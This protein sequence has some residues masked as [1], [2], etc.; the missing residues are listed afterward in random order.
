MKD[1]VV[2]MAVILPKSNFGFL[3]LCCSLVFTILSRF[4][5]TVTQT[6]TKHSNEYTETELHKTISVLQ[7]RLDSRLFTL[8]GGRQSHRDVLAELF[9]QIG[10]AHQFLSKRYASSKNL[11]FNETRILSNYHTA[12]AKSHY[13]IC[14]RFNKD[15][16]DAHVNLAMLSPPSIALQYLHRALVLS[17]SHLQCRINLGL[18]YHTVLQDYR[19]AI[20][21]FK[22]SIGYHPNSIDLHYNLA[23]SYA[24]VGQHNA[25]IY[26]YQRILSSIDENDLHSSIN[27][28]AVY[29]QQGDFFTALNFYRNAL[30]AFTFQLSRRV[31]LADDAVLD[32]FVNC[33]IFVL[34]DWHTLPNPFHYDLGIMC[35]ATNMTKMCNFCKEKIHS[36]L[37]DPY[38]KL[39]QLQNEVDLHYDLHLLFK[40][41]GNALTQIGDFSRAMGYYYATLSL[42]HHEVSIF[43]NDSCRNF[44]MNNVSKEKFH[45]INLTEDSRRRIRKACG[46]MYNL[47]IQAACHIFHSGRG[48]SFFSVWKWF[49][50]LIWFIDEYQLND[51]GDPSFLPFDTLGLPVDLEWRKRI[52]EK[53]AARFS[54]GATTN[55]SLH[56]VSSI[57]QRHTPAQPL[58]ISFLSQDFTD[59]P[60]AHLV[61]GLFVN[62]R[63]FQSD[64][65]PVQYLVYSY[66]KND[67][68]TCRHNIEQL[69]GGPST[70]R[71][72]FFDL[73]EADD[74]TAIQSV[75]GIPHDDTSGC[76][77]KT[78]NVSNCCYGGKQ[79]DIVFDL[80]G[81]TFKGRP[82]LVAARLAP[83]Q[84][85]YLV[86]PGTS[87]SATTDYIVGDK[88]VTPPE[89]APF[90]TEKLALMPHSYQANYYKRYVNEESF[91]ERGSEEW[92]SI[93]KREGLPTSR[94]V[95]VF[96][97]FNKQDKLEPMI[98][99]SWMD[100]LSQVS[101]SVLWLL[102]PTHTFQ[103][104]DG[105]K[106]VERNV[107]RQATVSGIL[108][109]DRIIFARRVTKAMH[110]YR[111]WAAD[112]FLDTHLYGAHTSA[113]DALITG[114]PVLTLVGETFSSRVGLSLLE[115][116]DAEFSSLLTSWSF[117]E[118]V[119]TAADFAK[120]MM[121][122]SATNETLLSL[123]VHQLRR[124]LFV[125][126]HESHLF[127]DERYTKNFNRMARAM[128]EVYLVVGSRMHIIV[129]D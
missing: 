95:L 12:E 16:V 107:L 80:Q 27:L 54:V 65:M 122:A 123:E 43:E 108:C 20:R 34:N 110:L 67:N 117:D 21:V 129:I 105:Y 115:N 48:G 84:V 64:R 92:V 73:S 1:K 35:N 23:K 32:E 4:T 104:D 81:F 98:F 39:L 40:N 17:P 103:D 8:H 83:I 7:E 14:L 62:N 10:L 29:H 77:S 57:A 45:R 126:S 22:D 37:K 30:K 91:I 66:G 15:H 88:F 85:N 47:L 3:L 79:S 36:F 2:I 125:R 58:V 113:S 94:D 53:H 93:R 59:H 106:V 72:N 50:D 13:S 86:F 41:I 97:N 74:E 52:A 99:S 31:R 55:G 60:T 33:H 112:L 24:A 120:E 114:L 49:D 121:S 76:S 25:A 118:Y 42:V 70:Q 28:A 90:Y 9:F 18:H 71:G 78:R 69:V 5:L 101:N 44:L 100:I 82:E 56:V 61:E 116:I 11:P 127:D 119:T 68:S 96:A 19:E 102:E 6:V 46:S 38:S 124:R 89:H 63:K 109:S 128:Q 75:R 51:G 111:M 87:G 26:H